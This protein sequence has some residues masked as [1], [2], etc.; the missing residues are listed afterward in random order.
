MYYTVVINVVYVL[1]V[2]YCS[3]AMK[4]I[5]FQW[6]NQY[7]A[8]D[9]IQT[10]NAAARCAINDRFIHSQRTHLAVCVH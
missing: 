2:T 5:S 8:T 3:V 7:V 9:S 4:L 10:R 6:T 1:R